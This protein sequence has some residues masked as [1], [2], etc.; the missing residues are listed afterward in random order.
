VTL[1]A[2]TEHTSRPWRIHELTRDVRLEDLSGLPALEGRDD[3]PG[4]VQLI[5]SSDPSQSSSCAVR[6]LFAIRWKLGD[7][8]LG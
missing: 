1:L 3:F 5:A 4:A 7:D 8:E 6:T 2:N